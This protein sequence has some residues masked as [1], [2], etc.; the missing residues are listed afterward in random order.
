MKVLFSLLLSLSPLLAQQAN[1]KLNDLSVSTALGGPEILEVVKNA[2][3]I[4]A[5]RVDS[6]V[7]ESEAEAVK[8]PE[9]IILDEPV[10][11]TGKESDDLRAAL[12]SGSTYLS[13]S[14]RCV[15]RANVRYAF[16]ASPEEKVEFVLCFGC[17]EMEVWHKGKMV[18]FGPFD[19]GY[20]RLLDVTK[21]IFPKDEFIAA[22][23]TKIFEE[24]AA[25]MREATP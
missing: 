10:A 9:L 22:F 2:K 6:K 14:K 17:G 21:R 12:T 18:S 25:R 15:F 24:R 23:D 1:P 20:A 16:I 13:T 3:T 7:A 19:G 11:V 8:H 5:Q 4:T